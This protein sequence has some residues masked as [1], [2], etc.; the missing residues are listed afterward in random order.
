MPNAQR[1]AR[2]LLVSILTA[3][4]LLGSGAAAAA[5]TL[6]GAPP[7]R[8]PASALE[9]AN[10]AV[11]GVGHPVTVRF[12]APVG[13]RAAAERAVEITTSKPVSGRF[14][15]LDDRRVQWVPDHLWPG[16]TTVTVAVA[17]ARTE[18]QVGDEFVA[19]A[20]RSTHQFTV[21]LNGEVV[22]TMPAS[23]GK[24]G[25][26]TPVGTF[27]VLEKFRDLVMDSSTYGVPID[28]PEGYR[29]DTEY[30]VRLTWGGIFV[31]AA[32][33]S[34]DSQGYANVSHGCI[35]LSTE[36]AQWYFDRVKIGDPV[37]VEG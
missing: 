12:G 30:A 3:M 18:F 24:P 2:L 9:P 13:D 16:H 8:L 20:N 34:V 14:A 17:G 22:R 29:L 5:G 6:G 7:T 26:E 36:N 25:Y 10:G 33:W 15:W 37:I 32:P 28:S 35:N 11:V 21:I 27:S 31:H 1:V 19:V 23:M 4:A